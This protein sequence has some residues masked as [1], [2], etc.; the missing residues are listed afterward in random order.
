MYSAE[1]Y[2]PGIK[3]LIRENYPYDIE[4]FGKMIRSKM[5][6]LIMFANNI[7]ISEEFLYLLTATE[8]IH[9]AS[10]FHDDVIDADEIR[11]SP[12]ID[13]KTAVLYGNILLT[14][15]IDLLLK[16]DNKE[17]IIIFNKA[18]Q[19]MCQ[20]EL[21]QKSQIGIIPK[22]DDYM[23]KSRLK[24]AELFKTMVRGIYILSKGCIE[25]K[26]IEFAE[27]YGT[28]FQ[29]KND[30][31]NYLGKKTDVK[32]GVYTVPYIFADSIDNIEKPSIEKTVGLIDNY[33]RKAKNCLNVL[34]ESDYKNK[35]IGVTE[36]LH[37]KS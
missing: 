11:R 24:T 23:E 5:G 16:I 4:D 21:I 33:I 8:L 26:M 1:D 25:S 13:N 22:L 12:G 9:N 36:C 29:I 14:K 7:K 10:L 2:L 19:S 32:N 34:E 28:A 30:F 37:I 20:G 31:D 27:Y 3:D 15:A 17:L 6:L 18:I 35:L